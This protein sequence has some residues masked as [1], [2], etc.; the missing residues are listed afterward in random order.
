MFSKCR[1]SLLL[2]GPFNEEIPENEWIGLNF[3][4]VIMTTELQYYKKLMVG[5]NILCNSFHELNG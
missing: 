5:L 4:Q 3:N 2:F 1:L